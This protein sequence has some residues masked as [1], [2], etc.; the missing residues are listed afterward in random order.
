MEGPSALRS[1]RLV[2]QP[3]KDVRRRAPTL[4]GTCGVAL[5]VPRRG[6]ASGWI[7]R[8]AGAQAQ[9]R[10]GGV[11]QQATIAAQRQVGVSK[12]GRLWLRRRRVLAVGSSSAARHR[13]VLQRRVHLRQR[14]AL[15]KATGW[16][17]LRRRSVAG[18]PLRPLS[19][20]PTPGVVLRGGAPALAQGGAAPLVG[21]EIA[22]LLRTP[23]HRSSWQFQFSDFV[24][25][26]TQPQVRYRPGYSRYW[27]QYRRVFRLR[28][29]AP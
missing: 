25:T 28:F 15:T 24:K 7:R 10:S 12:P 5:G 20:L 21:A 3:T 1:R 23:S 16:R 8:R 11:T 22:A 19:Y 6:R 4:L 14:W 2:G 13:S 17:G 18:Q 27:R 29:W 9:S 26:F